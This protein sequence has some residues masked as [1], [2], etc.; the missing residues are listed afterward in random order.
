MSDDDFIANIG[1]IN[2]LCNIYDDLG[3]DRTG[4][5]KKM[6]T[7][8]SQFSR[9][10][11][12]KENI[13]LAMPLIQALYRYIY[14]RGDNANHGLVN[15]RNSFIEMCCKAVAAYKAKPM[16]HSS[17]YLYARMKADY[18]H[19]ASKEYSTSVNAYLKDLD[20]VSTKERIRRLK[21][22]QDSV[23]HAESDDCNKW[24]ETRKC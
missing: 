5:R 19:C 3:L 16:M 4:I 14:G 24:I 13:Q 22:Y 8:F 1:A 20:N 21:A 6:D 23:G 11:Y 12:S 9:R 2:L 10:I 17:D 15:R 7:L 18:G